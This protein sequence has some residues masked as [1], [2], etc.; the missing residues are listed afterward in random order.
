M[1]A[2][3]LL[4]GVWLLAIIISYDPLA[5]N[6]PDDPSNTDDYPE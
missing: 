4:I 3:G 6:I 2:L 1:E 5:S